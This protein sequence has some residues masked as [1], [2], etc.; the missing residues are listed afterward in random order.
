MVLV[1]LHTVCAVGVTDIIGIGFIVTFCAT[2]QV[3]AGM[4]Y[5]IVVT[6][7]VTPV[8]TPLVEPTVATPV[9]VLVQTPPGVASARVIDEVPQIVKK[10]PVI[11]ATTALTLTTADAEHPP[12]AV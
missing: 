10:V 11:G 3:E 7:E 5:D 6:P 2:A 4:L 8:T 9:E 12:G 1:L